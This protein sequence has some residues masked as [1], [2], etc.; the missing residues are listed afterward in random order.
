MPYR[1][2]IL[3]DEFLDEFERFLRDK[4]YL[5]ISASVAGDVVKNF[6]FCR[7]QTFHYKL[8]QKGVIHEVR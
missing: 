3:F 1:Q 5:Y 8:K 2:N 7:L 6:F 4:V